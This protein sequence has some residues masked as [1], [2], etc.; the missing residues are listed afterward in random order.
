VV[1]I[2][3]ASVTY[4]VYE[5]DVSYL[6]DEWLESKERNREWVDYN[7]AV[8]RLRWKPELVQSIMLSSVAP[9]R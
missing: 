6:A 2:P 3:T 8:K 7:E 9:K 1:T 5:L 4:H